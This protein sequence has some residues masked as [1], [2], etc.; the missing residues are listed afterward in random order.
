MGR[1]LMKPIIQWLETIAGMKL[2]QQIAA[3]L[4]MLYLI[5]LQQYTFVGILVSLA[6]SISLIE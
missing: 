2:S 5:A 3:D 6:G 1:K 4:Q